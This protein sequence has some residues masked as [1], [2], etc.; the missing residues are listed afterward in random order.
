M[1]TITQAALAAALAVAFLSSPAEAR[2]HRDQTVPQRAQECLTS[3]DGPSQGVG[4]SGSRAASVAPARGLRKETVRTARAVA[5][6]PAGAVRASPSVSTA[7]VTPSNG[8]R[9]P[10]SLRCAY[11]MMLAYGLDDRDLWLARNWAV[12]FTH[13][14]QPSPGAVGVFSR[15]RSGTAGHVVKVLAVLGTKLRVWSPNGGRGNTDV[16][17]E[18][19]ANPPGLIAWVIPGQ[20]V[21]GLAR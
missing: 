21:A 3:V 12:K 20:R 17:V 14:A 2:R 15:G 19:P 16:V 13:V 9:P 7:R 5:G 1:K 6:K 10:W 18:I 4:C 8:R 11:E